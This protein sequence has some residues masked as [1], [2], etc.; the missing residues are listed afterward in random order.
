MSRRA[1]FCVPIQSEVLV[2]GI[3]V[4][5]RKM[6]ARA[7]AGDGRSGKACRFGCDAEGFEKLRRYADREV[8]RFGAKGWV[9][10][11]E[12]TGHYGE[13]L[14]VWMLQRGVKVYAVQ[15]LKTRRAKE[16]YDGTW[17]KTDE[18]DALV[19]ADLCRRGLG[20]PWRVLAGPFAS[21]RVL[22]RRREQL[23][24]RRRRLVNRLHRHRDVVFPELG[25]LFTML[26]GRA[27][28][29]VLRHVATPGAVLELGV[30]QLAQELY[31]ASR[32]QLGRERAE[33]MVQAAARSV[34]VAEAALEHQFAIEQLLDELEEVLR[35]LG[36]VERRMEAE[37]RQV[38]Y[39]GHLLT[40]PG[41]GPITVA[42]LLGEFGDLRNYRVAKQLIK[43]AGLD[44]AEDSS[45][46]R[47]GHH[48]ISRRGRRYARQI[49]YMA[50]LTAGRTALSERRRRLVEEKGKSAPTAIV[51][52]A[53]ALLRIS[54]AL[55]RDGADFDARRHT[56][57]QEVTMAA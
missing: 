30:E 20:T 53:C 13:P 26:T 46:E 37:L 15:P 44:L 28:R 11:M 29:W 2:V 10:A 18:K 19:I 24:C 9:A 36:Q 14:A 31:Q 43:M 45:G 8:K 56:A 49:L 32:W 51:A 40:M 38:P 5:K 39:A 50:A 6:L 42:T 1:Q 22:S 7:V 21:L 12:P 47:Q 4:A 16:L 17:R 52:N 33:A 54:H 34:G 48:H 3:D 35:Q 57:P 41:F 25:G 27:S 55:V 23:V